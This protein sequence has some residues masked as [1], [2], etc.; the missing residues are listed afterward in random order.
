[1]LEKKMI[2]E[3][4]LSSPLPENKKRENLNNFLKS[5]LYGC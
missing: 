2:T 4:P 1:L 3:V 5:P